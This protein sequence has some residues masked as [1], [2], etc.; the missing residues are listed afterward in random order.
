MKW[1]VLLLAVTGCAGTNQALEDAAKVKAELESIRADAIALNQ[2]LAAVQAKASGY[3]E[4]AIAVLHETEAVAPFACSLVDAAPDSDTTKGAK[5]ACAKQAMLPDAV[6]NVEKAC[7]LIGG[8][9]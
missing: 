3:C 4:Q 2:K 8:A 7:G 5:I 1:I 6:R 9:Q